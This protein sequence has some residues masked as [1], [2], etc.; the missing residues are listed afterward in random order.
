MTS[1][2]YRI[3]CKH[4]R[5]FVKFHT[6]DR[7]FE[8]I[9]QGRAYHFPAKVAICPKCGQ[10]LS[11]KEIREYNDHSFYR[12]YRAMNGLVSF[13]K[14]RRM[15]SKYLIGKKELSL[16]LGWDA[17]LFS[18]YY[19]G[20]LPSKEDSELLETLYD[21]PKQFLSYLEEHK[22]RIS[23]PVSYERS[24]EAAKKALSEAQASGPDK[25]THAIHYL[26]Y[27]CG[28]ISLFTLHKALYYAQGF[29]YAF[30][31]IFLF[32]E[33]CRAWINGPLYSGLYRYHTSY[34]YHPLD[35]IL[36]FDTSVFLNEE[37]ELLDSVIKHVCCYSEMILEPFVRGEQPWLEAQQKPKPAFPESNLHPIEV[38]L[39]ETRLISKESIAGYFTSVRKQ[40]HM[41]TPNDIRNYMQ[42]CLD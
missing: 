3:F 23:S 18:Q 38:T 21:D 2:T 26:L 11:S 39:E 8:K 40:F 25:M 41:K 17:D 7:E 20:T 16:L 4:C 1:S 15:P 5:S 31:G 37:L 42:T 33:D 24:R 29:S 35:P 34:Q 12:K 14:V 28:D 6:E 19:D 27:R 22:D 9:Y 10:T 32:E 13:E 30:R 36:P